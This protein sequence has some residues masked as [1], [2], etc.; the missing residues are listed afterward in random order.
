GTTSDREVFYRFRIG[1]SWPRCLGS[2]R[3]SGGIGHQWSGNLK[4]GNLKLGN[5]KPGKSLLS[6][7]FVPVDK[8]GRSSLVVSLIPGWTKSIV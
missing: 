1:G 6:W 5:L 2:T 8:V 7:V 3:I 4:L